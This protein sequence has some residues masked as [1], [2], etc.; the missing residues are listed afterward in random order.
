MAMYKSYSFTRARSDLVPTFHNMMTRTSNPDA[1]E[2]DVSPI[3]KKMKIQKKPHRYLTQ[4]DNIVRS[5]KGCRCALAALCQL[6]RSY[7]WWWYCRGNIP[8]KP[9]FVGYGCHVATPLRNEH[10]PW[11]TI[12]SARFC[13]SFCRN[14][15]T[16]LYRHYPGC[17]SFIQLESIH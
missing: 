3:S 8:S 10:S 17:N 11:G 2:T 4:P 16:F 7:G 12:L 6:F 15:P 14:G 13:Q 1:Y 9:T 5:Y